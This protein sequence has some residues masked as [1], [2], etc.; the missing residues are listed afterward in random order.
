MPR[1]ARI[2]DRSHLRIADLTVRTLTPTSLLNV[3]FPGY[4]L[5][6]IDR[7]AQEL[8]MSK[9]QMV[10]AMR[11]AGLEPVGRTFVANCC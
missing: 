9:T 11:D 6:A 5:D 8:G 4:I 1:N 2:A 3:E 7:L 10:I